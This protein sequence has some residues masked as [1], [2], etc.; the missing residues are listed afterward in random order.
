MGLLFWRDNAKLDLFAN[1]M[2][3]EFEAVIASAT[4]ESRLDRKTGNRM[5]KATENMLAR[6]RDYRGNNKLG[7]YKKARIAHRFGNKLTQMGLDD[8][9]VQDIRQQ[10]LMALAG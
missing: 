5:A 6:A 1:E 3:S 7:V 9:I 4:A 10:L 2:A 8:N